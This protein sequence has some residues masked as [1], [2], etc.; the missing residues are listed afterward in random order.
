VNTFHQE[1]WR[2]ETFQ[3]QSEL[4]WLHWAAEVEALADL[5]TLD[6]DQETDGYSMDFAYDAFCD[7]E[8]AESHAQRIRNI[9]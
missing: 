1:V 8:S 7:G 5:D 2:L 3:S 6:G 9:Q 4:T